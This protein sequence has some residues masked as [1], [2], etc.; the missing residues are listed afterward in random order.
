MGR[1]VGP[2]NRK[3][4]SEGWFDGFSLRSHL[5]TEFGWLR[6]LVKRV[7]LFCLFLLVGLL[8]YDFFSYG[9]TASSL[10]I[11]VEVRGN[12]MVPASEVRTAM[13]SQLPEQGETGSLLA[14][15]VDRVKD[16]IQQEIPRFRSVYVERKLPG[17]LIVDVE[18]RT[19]VAIVARYDEA[20]DNRMFLP[21]DREGVLFEARSKEWDRLK[22]TLP[23]ALG[24]EEMPVGSDGFQRRW[25]RVL[26][27]KDAFEQVF[28]LDML[29][30]IRVRPG[31]YA[32]VEI[33]RPSQL[34][35]KLGLSNYKRKFQQLDRMMGTDEFQ[36]IDEYI[37]LHDL[38]EVF[39]N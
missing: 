10:S 2:T 32:S 30:W 34:E 23:V 11:D 27:V 20:N 5:P 37:N 16:Q 38:N 39:V 15:S 4:R 12:R 21:A 24:L 36:T 31:G 33:T 13:E 29:N 3:K 1:R 28:V 18:E 25:D 22:N 17:R 19:P 14:V 6:W 9:M 35:I 7:G 8:A 26:R